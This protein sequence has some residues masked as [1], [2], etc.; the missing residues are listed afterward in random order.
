MHV[1]FKH[2]S[3]DSIHEADREL[4]CESHAFA[5]RYSGFTVLP[6][7]L[8]PKLQAALHHVTEQAIL[9][10][11]DAFRAGLHHNETG[12]GPKSRQSTQSEPLTEEEIVNF[13]SPKA[14]NLWGRPALELL[15]I[16]D[17]HA[18]ANRVIGDFHLLALVM[19]A[20]FTP[21]PFRWG[22][23]RDHGQ[24]IEPDSTRTDYLWFFCILDDFTAESGGTWV[25]PG[26]HRMRGDDKAYWDIHHD[27]S[28]DL[29]PTKIQVNAKAG[30]VLI[31]NP[32]CIHAAGFNYTDKPRR[33][34]N[35]RLG[36]RRPY[37]FPPHIRHYDDLDDRLRE[38]LPDRVARML[39]SE[40]AQDYAYPVPR[41][42]IVLE[43]GL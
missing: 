27:P 1:E 33:A 35:M 16:E 24:W 4:W 42:R 19:N 30:D 34:M 17:F 31:V 37:A 11:Q 21:K 32:N 25:V 12:F 15:D 36:A 22:F 43:S 28:S 20:G 3:M 39:K 13:R 14:C 2:L 6:R 29:Y 5:L 40:F 9:D 41:K 10:H 18:I 8:S 7:V 38:G 26:S 23:H